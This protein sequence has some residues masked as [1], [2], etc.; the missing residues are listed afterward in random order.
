MKRLLSEV[1]RT[2]EPSDVA[3]IVGRFDKLRE[4][5][6]SSVTLDTLLKPVLGPDPPVRPNELVQKVVEPALPFVGTWPT[7]RN[8]TPEER[9]ERIR[10][11]QARFQEREDFIV[12]NV[13]SW[14]QKVREYVED[15]VGDDLG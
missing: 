9:T 14:C 12:D 6:T 7:Q 4:G 1:R 3:W 8:E 5:W 11:E 13:L 15:Q 2:G 10:R